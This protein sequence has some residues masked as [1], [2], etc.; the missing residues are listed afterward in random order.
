VFDDRSPGMFRV[1]FGH[2]I[3]LSVG[4]LCCVGL[5]VPVELIGD[6][7]IGVSGNLLIISWFVGAFDELAIDEGGSGADEG[8]EVGVR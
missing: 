4:S 2:W 1:Q 7:W 8:N 5:G 6:L 3:V